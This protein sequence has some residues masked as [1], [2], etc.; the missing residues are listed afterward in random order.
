MF[1][2]RPA[3]TSP[4]IEVRCHGDFVPWLA[5]SRGTLAVTTYNSGK[6]ALFCAPDGVLEC[7]IV[8][9]PRPM[10]LAFDG[11]QLAVAV[12]RAIVVWN[13]AETRA[14]ARFAYRPFRLHGEYPTGRLDAHDL[15]FDSRG[16]VLANT[17][18]NCLARPSRRARYRRLWRPPFLRESAAGDCCHLNGVGVR[19]GQPALATAFGVAVEAGGW[20][21]ADRFHSGVALDVPTGRIV[22]EGLCMPHSPRWDGRQ[23]WLCNS[24]LGALCRLDGRGGACETVAELPGF[25]RGLYLAEDRAVVGDRKSVV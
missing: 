15:A 23:W 10:G 19:D 17:R 21:T 1:P 8:R 14:D 11:Q 18:F 5:Q 2:I 25:V 9:L 22:A 4:G 7:S 12:R 3:A 24:G 13:S 16:L 20:R 6:L